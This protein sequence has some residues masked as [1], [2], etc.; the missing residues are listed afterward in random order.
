MLK[1]L[2][3]SVPFVSLLG[4]PMVASAGCQSTQ[5]IDDDS[6]SISV[7]PA[8]VFTVDRTAELWVKG[9]ACPFCVQNVDKR[10]A[11]VTGV[12][13]VDVDLPTGKVRVLLSDGHPASKDDLVSAVAAS[14]FT[15]DRIEMP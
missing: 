12:D 6:K 5:T 1:K 2:L 3:K 11:A 13:D 8:D 4:V 9:L 15:L 7:E 10:I 14:G